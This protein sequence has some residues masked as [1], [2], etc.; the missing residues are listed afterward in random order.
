MSKKTFRTVATN[1]FSTATQEKEA[2]KPTPQRKAGKPATGQQRKQAQPAA[3]PAPQE[4]E[5]K[6][7]RVQLLFKPSTYEMAKE[8]AYKARVSLNEYIHQLIE[9]KLK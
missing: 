2:P 4:T 1:F 6:A 5:T 7:R 9:E 8:A 3:K